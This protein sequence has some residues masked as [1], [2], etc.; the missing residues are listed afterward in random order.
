MTEDFTAALAKK[1]PLKEIL[2]NDDWERLFRSGL[3]SKDEQL[4]TYLSANETLADMIEC[5]VNEEERSLQDASE[6][7]GVL[8]TNLDPVNDALVANHLPALF[9]YLNRK[10]MNPRR[11]YFFLRLSSFLFQNRTHEALSF[12]IN[13]EGFTP[14]LVRHLGSPHILQ[15]IL[16]IL[17]L[18]RQMKNEGHLDADWS[19]KT[20]LV[21]NLVNVLEEDP[22][23]T[24]DPVFKFL[25]EICVHNDPTSDFIKSTILAKDGAFTAC[26]VKLTKVKHIAQDAIRL[27]D[28]HILKIVMLNKGDKEFFEKASKQLLDQR[29]V[30]EEMLNSNSLMHVLS[31]VKFI[32]ALVKHKA[33]FLLD[34]GLKIC[35]DLMFRFPWSNILHNSIVTVISSVFQDENEEK[36]LES[37][38]DAGLLK[39][40]VQGLAS[41]TPSGYKPHLRQIAATMQMTRSAKALE[42][43]ATDPLW[44]KY[45]QAM[46]TR[47]NPDLTF[48]EAEK[49]VVKRLQ[50]CLA[51]CDAE[52]Q[53]SQPPTQ[54]PTQT[55]DQKTEAPQ[56]HPSELTTEVLNQETKEVVHQEAHKE[57]T[58]DEAHKDE[59]PKDE[60]PKDEAPK[61][62]AHKE[63]SHKE[64]AHKDE[65]PKE[66]HKEEVGAQ[67]HNEQK[68]TS[69]SGGSTGQGEQVEVKH[70]EEKKNEPGNDEHKNEVEEKK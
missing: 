3:R 28:E 22:Q 49:L 48:I 9:Q 44:E 57:E 63:E 62:E 27:L 51:E 33:F 69:E 10:T 8:L 65:A 30:F 13:T 34:N 20:D 12:A 4:L 58:K 54:T 47:K 25:Q 50:E 16:L 15:L 1:L 42:R 53:P 41:E 60:A 39:M 5:L 66:A 55:D 68:K 7:L 45:W 26:L 32:H 43:F 23:N 59:A 14:K 21:G 36:F 11:M 61:D 56:S 6:V 19:G 52:G 2:K 24:L 38:L 35:I 18:E 40:V 29:S 31:G 64:E 46:E 37:L 70:E 67:E 17:N